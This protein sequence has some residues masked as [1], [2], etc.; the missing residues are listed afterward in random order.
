[1]RQVHRYIGTYI[2]IFNPTEKYHLKLLEAKI[3][4][5]GNRGS[6]MTFQILLNWLRVWQS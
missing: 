2:V 6:I 3:G 4:V 1:M 5:A